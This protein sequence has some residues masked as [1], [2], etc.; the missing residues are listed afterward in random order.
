MPVLPVTNFLSSGEKTNPYPYSLSKA[1]KL[2]SSHGWKINPGAQTP[3]RSRAPV[4]SE[5]GAGIPAGTP[6]TFNM[7][8]AT[9]ITTQTQAVN[10]EISSWE[11]AG[12]H[13]NET[14]STFDT[15][16]GNATACTPGPELHVG[17]PG[18]GRELGLLPRHLPDR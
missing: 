2:L 3:A 18:L 13:V 9:G 1:E 14:T 5:C 15:V 10:D 7:Q 4:P 11:S 17:V 8:F 12:I 6:L 16:I